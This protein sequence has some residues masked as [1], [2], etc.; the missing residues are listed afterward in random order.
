VRLEREQVETLARGRLDAE[1]R[2]LAERRV[3]L[4]LP[5]DYL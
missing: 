3:L 1:L 5:A 4:D 2:L